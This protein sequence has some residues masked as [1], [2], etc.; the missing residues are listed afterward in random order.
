MYNFND[1]TLRVPLV[2]RTIDQITKEDFSLG[3]RLTTSQSPE[4]DLGH[5]YSVSTLQYSEEKY[6]DFLSGPSYLLSRQAVKVIYREALNMP[7]FPL[8]D[9]FLTGQL[10]YQGNWQGNSNDLILC[11]TAFYHIL[12]FAGLAGLDI[13]SGRGIFK[14]NI[15][16]KCMTFLSLF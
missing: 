16:I 8:E 12:I 5:K 3:G 6:P 2:L 9:V 15:R 7:Y 11:T 13:W 14:T 4:R 10:N 1:P